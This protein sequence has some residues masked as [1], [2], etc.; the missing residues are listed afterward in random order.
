MFLGH[1]MVD[2]HLNE[3]Y[4]IKDA[5]Q[6]PEILNNTDTMIEQVLRYDDERISKFTKE[7][8]FSTNLKIVNNDFCLN[9]EIDRAFYLNEVLASKFLLLKIMEINSPDYI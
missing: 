8:I 7:K 6:K 4:S 2:I 3:I 1:S 9:N 5:L